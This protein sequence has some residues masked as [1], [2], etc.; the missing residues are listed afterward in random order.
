MNPLRKPRKIS[1]NNLGSSESHKAARGLQ[2]YAI[3][4]AFTFMG[5]VLLAAAG[6]MDFIGNSDFP[7]VIWQLPHVLSI[8]I[9]LVLGQ[10]FFWTILWPT[11]VLY[12]AV[13]GLDVTVFVWRAISIAKVYQGTLPS[14][15]LN[16]AFLRLW[17][18]EFVYFLLICIDAGQIIR[19]VSIDR[20]EKNY[21]SDDEKARNSAL[22]RPKAIKFFSVVQITAIVDAAYTVF[23]FLIVFYYLAGFT[24]TNLVWLQSIHFISW[25]VAIIASSARS[26]RWMV[27]SAVIEVFALVFDIIVFTIYLFSLIDCGNGTSPQSCTNSQ[28]EEFLLLLLTLIY[29]VIDVIQAIFLFLLLQ[30]HRKFDIHG[31]KERS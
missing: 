13:F 21:L 9:A 24:V 1:S 23:Y 30:I 28:L 27:P 29:I 22:Y 4:E 19:L 31:S 18:P 7:G 16:D 12:G 8:L 10:F 6:Y 25:L 14:Y 17:V 15:Y 26:V 20:H 11:V 2:V 5:L 3:I